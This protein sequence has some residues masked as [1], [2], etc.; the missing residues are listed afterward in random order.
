EALD[1]L[2][3]L[4]EMAE[5]VPN[6]V[7]VQ[8]EK[9]NLLEG[10]E[11][12]ELF[13]AVGRAQLSELSQP[14]AAAESFSSLLIASPGDAEAL[15]RLESIY[16][17]LG[18]WT[19]LVDVLGQRLEYTSEESEEKE[20]RY[21]TAQ[22]YEDYLGDTE[23]AI[24]TYRDVLDGDPSDGVAL[25]ALERIYERDAKWPEL[26]GILERQ[27]EVAESDEWQDDITLR[28]AILRQ[29]ELDDVAG[30]VTLY[31]RVL[32]R[33]PA[34]PTALSALEGILT[35]SDEHRVDTARALVKAYR[36]TE[37]WVDA[38]RVLEIELSAHED[39]GEK[40]AALEAILGLSE[41]Q[42]TDSSAAFSAAQRLYVLN[43]SERWRDEVERLAADVEGWTALANTYREV[44]TG[45]GEGIDE[46]SLM[47]RLGELESEH[48]G[49]PTEAEQTLLSAIEISAE[50]TAVLG[51]LERLYAS[52]NQYD[53]LL[54]VLEQRVDIALASGDNP[55]A[56]DYL[57]RSALIHD[58]VLSDPEAAMTICRR[59][60]EIDLDDDQANQ[61]L[62]RLLRQVEQWDELVDLL[63]T[64]I[65]RATDP[66]RIAAKTHALGTVLAWRLGRTSDSVEAFARVLDIDP[67]FQ[68]AV[69]ALESILDE[70]QDNAIGARV[71]QVLERVY[72]E[73][74]QNEKLVRS[75]R[76]QAGAAADSDPH[77]ASGMLREA[78]QLL[79][80]QLGAAEPAYECVSEA[81][82]LAPTDQSGWDELYR[83]AEGTGGWSALAEQLAT[84]LDETRVTPEQRITLGLMLGQIREQEL[85]ESEAARAAYEAVADNEPSNRPALDALERIYSGL[86]LWEPLVG[87]FEQ[88]IDLS[89]D[90]DEQRDYLLKMARLQESVLFDGEAS[91]AAYRRVLE[92][93]P[94]NEE[95]NNALGN[96]FELD[97]RFEELATLLERQSVLESDSDNR[98]DILLR[99]GKT[100][101]KELTEFER[102]ANVYGQVLE[103]RP[104][105]ADALEQ[106]GAML[107]D[108]RSRDGDKELRAR[109][110]S[111]IESS[112]DET[113]WAALVD[114]SEAKLEFIS[115]KDRRL[116]IMVRAA[117]LLEQRGGDLHGAMR[118]WCRAFAEHPD[119]LPAIEAMERLAAETHDF[120]SL[121]TAYEQGLPA[122]KDKQ[123]AVSLYLRGASILENQIGDVRRAIAML[124]AVLTI[125]PSHGEA[126]GRLETLLESNQDFAAL[127]KVL[128]HKV[129][130][131]S[132]PID[133]K[134]YYYQIAE[135]HE[136]KLEDAAEAALTYHRILELDPEDVV[137]MESL[138]RLLRSQ[139]DFLELVTIL[140]AKVEIVDSP[141]E[142]RR[143][144][145]EIAEVY[146]NELEDIASAIDVYRLLRS[147]DSDD[148]EAVRA[149]DRLFQKDEQWAEL[150]DIIEVQRSM[151]DDPS[152]QLQ[153]DFRSAQLLQTKLSQVSRAIEVYRSI[154]GA[155]PSF[156]PALAALEAL[157]GGDNS[158][159]AAEVLDQYFRRAGQWRKV[160][161]LLAQQY[162][163]TAVVD[164][165]YQLTRETARVYE[166]QLHEPARAFQ[167]V[168]RAFAVK[169]GDP[170]AYGEMTRLAAEHGFWEAL[171]KVLDQVAET[172]DSVRRKLLLRAASVYRDKLYNVPMAVSRY[173]GVLEAD[174]KDREA[175]SALDELYSREQDWVSLAEILKRQ[176]DVAESEAEALEFRF[177]LAYIV[178]TVFGE[179]KKALELYSKLLE[180]DRSH[181][182]AIE[183][184]IRLGQKAEHNPAVTDVLTQA[185]TEAK[186]W[187]RLIEL[188]TLALKFAQPGERAADLLKS[189]AELYERRFE[190]PR[191]AFAFYVQA[192]RQAPESG[193]LRQKLE[194]MGAELEAWADLARVF[195]EAR[196]QVADEGQRN[197]LTR[198]AAEWYDSKLGRPDLAEE[199]YKELLQANPGDMAT[200]EA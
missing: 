71:A 123:L 70:N 175:L 90:S 189:M 110:V 45:E 57:H 149:L 32:G 27:A 194:T 101:E 95:A 89:T 137:A 106:L 10:E 125:E 138:E 76:L 96:R 75:L 176:V 83:L 63:Q 162:Q 161:E 113:Q 8:A 151:V 49:Q 103:A 131:S 105:D 7:S 188:Y 98:A 51:A 135:I 134:E 5:D 66:E 102:A 39:D 140:Q 93:E 36:A 24:V 122:A 94:T 21:S 31:S 40:E 79:E 12:V 46:V 111:L 78:A 67:D 41:Q 62:E 56:L 163:A 167:E 119:H 124:D 191:Q 9:A 139:G 156:G 92:I 154:L 100:V 159:E 164:K 50:N 48:L 86:Q 174:P 64:Q 173:R 117:Q 192:L 69:G 26:A 169:P 73:S 198:R 59:A 160:V 38:V 33:Q 185:F 146:E 170:E 165:K 4:Y 15:S 54:A 172:D 153:L 152:T 19:E 199:R 55:V 187:S 133:Q 196:Q 34:N 118:F 132:D 179:E 84:E 82:R 128:N 2:E 171:A 17:Q 108:L 81:V 18:K 47:L 11:Q 80:N 85:G 143:I 25:N 157:V 183:S 184:L 87:L 150:L 197:E 20:I 182:R 104:G 193:G 22:V 72:R 23:S 136:N 107:A 148:I 121:A 130:Q 168:A 88:R 127:V 65:D 195:D 166:N 77:R 99:L 177:R 1:S 115:D 142:R 58:S 35:G 53:K 13:R 28:L 37:R 129:D 190:D 112:L 60:L 14:E 29:A 180:A 68:G 44:L 30:A 61:N 126:I 141:S 42:L 114:L 147:D 155:D 52:Q 43:P 3:L 186:A 145:D 109:I 120:G 97:G 16:R 6:R 116:P 178:E 144:W 91:V 181:E 74:A 158:D 200:L